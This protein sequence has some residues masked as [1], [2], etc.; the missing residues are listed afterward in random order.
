[1]RRTA[2]RCALGLAL[3]MGGTA[4]AAEIAVLSA[5]AMR[6]AL[7]GL[8]ADWSHETGHRVT[9]SYAAA[10]DIRKR[11]AAGERPD[12]LILPRENFADLERQALVSAAPRDL[13]V[14]K[15]GVAVRSGAT[16]PD[17]STPAA[18]AETLKQ[19]Q[20][21]TYMD[22]ERGTSGKHFDE[23]VL[24]ALGIRDSVRAK[25]VLGEGGYIAEK[26]ARGEVELAVHQVTEILP[27]KGVA[28]VGTLPEPLQ[29]HT[30]YAGAV[31]AGAPAGGVAAMLLGHLTG[32]AAR[33]AFTERGFSAP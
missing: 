28:L 14:V 15:I 26:V 27:V 10:G 11:L 23:V 32:P 19:A 12:L 30:V 13:A 21:L 1:M 2:W 29:K 3:A 25:A 24:P 16:L 6:S 5:G 20:S 7:P 33:S 22:P 9:V 8:V 17:I 4:I 31:L 18:F